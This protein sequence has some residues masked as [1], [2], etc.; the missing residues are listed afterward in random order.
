MAKWLKFALKKATKSAVF[1]NTL[2]KKRRAPSWIKFTK[3]RPQGRGVNPYGQPD[4]KI[5]VSFDDF[6]YF[7]TH[8]CWIV[9]TNNATSMQSGSKWLH[10]PTLYSQLPSSTTVAK[11]TLLSKE[12]FLPLKNI[13]VDGHCQHTPASRR[14]RKIYKRTPKKPTGKGQPRCTC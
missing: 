2:L 13:L 3:N 7:E 8:P 12:F 5:S 4:H 11:H 10:V 9:G 6:S 1:F 14:G